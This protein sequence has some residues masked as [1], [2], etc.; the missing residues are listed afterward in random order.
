MSGYAGVFV[1]YVCAFMSM[2]FVI[3]IL[4]CHYAIKRAQIRKRSQSAQMLVYTNP[5]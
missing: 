1:C 4:Y 5:L 2:R 3:Q